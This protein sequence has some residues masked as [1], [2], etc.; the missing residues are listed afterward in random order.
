M[1][2]KPFDVTFE[3]WIDKQIREATER[4]D[5]DNLPGTG[6]PL[7]DAGQGY[8]DQWWIKSYLKREGL[9]AEG[10]LPPALQLRREIERLPAQIADLRSER[11]V[12]ELVADLNHR[13]VEWMRA[14]SG[15][16]V[17]VS[18]VDVEQIVTEWRAQ[19]PASRPVQP[20]QE[21]PSRR[22]RWWRRRPQ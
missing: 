10:M 22:R 6:K 4:G 2:R 13:I 1:T 11:Q 16:L 7:P 3:T 19:R 14:P 5:F 20:Q 12:R 15:P 8:D 18:R 17:K 21:E 9:T